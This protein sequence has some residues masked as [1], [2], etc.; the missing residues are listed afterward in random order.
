MNYLCTETNCTF[1]GDKPYAIRIPMEVY[2]RHNMATPLCPYCGAEL[3]KKG[4]FG[5]EEAA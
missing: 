4:A 3:E 5:E 1:E 2:E